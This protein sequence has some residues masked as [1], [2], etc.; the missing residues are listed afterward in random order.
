ML[1]DFAESRAEYLAWLETLTH[2]HRRRI[3]VRVLDL[4]HKRIATIYDIIDG[5]ITLKVSRGVS[6]VLTLTVL[7]PTRSIGWEPDSPSSLPKH[8]R[9]MVQVFYEVAV[10]DYGW[11][12]CPVGVFVVDE[13]D[14]DGAEV[15][16]VGS[17][18]EALAM[19]SF[20]RA[21]TWKKGRKVVEVIEEILNLA[22]EKSSRIHLPNINATLAH[23]LT[24]SRTDKPWVQARKLAHDHD[25]VLFYNGRGHVVMRREPTAPTLT[26]GRDWLTDGLRIDRPKL[27]LFN[28]WV[29]LGKKPKGNKQRLSADVWLPATNPFSGFA[30]G[31]DVDGERVPRWLLD[32]VDRPGADTK[33]KC[34]AIA[35]RLRDK[36]IRFQAEVSFDC[37]PFPNVEE[38]DLVKARDPLAGVA[39]VQVKEATIPL[40]AGSQTIGAIS[41]ISRVKRHGSYPANHGG[42]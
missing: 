29:V 8:L 42:L 28:R 41:R 9:R 40:A 35:Q 14:R 24:V 16:I 26:V 33:A 23:D 12:S 38:W 3:K 20:G 7:D 31:R 39:V 21:H 19:G 18:K 34:L 6:R 32:E 4:N 13:V 25:F 2:T 22:G 1:N 17:S 5:Q 30:L 11:V 27:V 36:A 10:P 37:L 15:S